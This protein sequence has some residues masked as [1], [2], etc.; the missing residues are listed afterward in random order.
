MARA[1]LSDVLAVAADY[2]IG[3]VLRPTYDRETEEWTYLKADQ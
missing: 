2:P 1:M 3:T